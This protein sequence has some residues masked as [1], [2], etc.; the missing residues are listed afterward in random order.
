VVGVEE[1]CIPLFDSPRRSQ[2]QVR[3]AEGREI[4]HNPVVR[5]P[6]LSQGLQS[7][8]SH[9]TPNAKLGEDGVRRGDVPRRR[10]SPLIPARSVT[11]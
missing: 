10:S 5:H 11:D 1:E 8:N 4:S 3:T 6:H 7:L 2:E 9:E